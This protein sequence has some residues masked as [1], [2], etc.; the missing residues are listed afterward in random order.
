MHPLTPDIKGLSDQELGNKITELERKLVQSYRM[1]N[2]ALSYQI[3]AI[4]EDYRFENQTRTRNQLETLMKQ[5]GK[6]L[7]SIIDIS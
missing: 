7:D 3:T 6:D 4:L 5:N 2:S 1:G